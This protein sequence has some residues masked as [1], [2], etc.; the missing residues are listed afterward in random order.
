MQAILGANGIIARELS[1]S[2]KEAGQTL[3]QVSRQPRPVFSDD[4]LHAADLLDAGAVQKAVAGCDVAYLVAGLP[5]DATTWS[6][7]WPRIM[8]HVIDACK[9]HD[10]RLVF[11][12]NVYAY[13]LV[14]GP[15]TEATPFNPNSRKGEAR[16]E[17]AT[18][19]LDEMQRGEL[20][21]LIARS[22][23]FYGPAATQSFTHATIFAR[24]AQGRPPQWAGN[25]DAEHT[26]NFTQD[27]GQ[28]LARLGTTA[29]AYGQTW[30]LPA[31]STPI[32]GRTFA[33]LACELAGQ[34]EK[35]QVAPAWL[36]SLLGLVNPI[37]RENREMMYQF[38]HD[39]CF[40]S[41]KI[42]RHFGLVATPYRQGIQETLQ[43]SNAD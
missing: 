3:R 21:A 39:Y 40:D 37:I 19:L 12:D 22:A 15:M 26:F 35:V 43:Y 1:T 11:L 2:L 42:E 38:E 27:I 14:N 41:R 5:Y 7:Q 8:R 36:L 17:T 25:P 30:H 23:D 6:A 16:A 20:Q 10:C 18:L 13:G 9:Q 33:H 32:S 28:A 24:L 29:A 4:D 34:P 31:D